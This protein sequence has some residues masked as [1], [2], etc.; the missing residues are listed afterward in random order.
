MVLSDRLLFEFL[1]TDSSKGS[2]VRDLSWV[3]SPVFPV[4][5]YF[6]IKRCHHFFFIKAGVLQKIYF[7]KEVHT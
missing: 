5:R 7:Q 1:V 6:F 4:C 2:S 3:V